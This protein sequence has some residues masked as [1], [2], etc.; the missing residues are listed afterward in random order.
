MKR[1]TMFACLALVLV[2]S[3]NAFASERTKPSELLQPTM[4]NSTLTGGVIDNAK[5]SRDTA[6]IIG[7]GPMV[8][9]IPEGEDGIGV[10]YTYVN[11]TFED[12]NGVASWNAWTHYDVTQPTVNHWQVSTFRA[13]ELGDPGNKAAWCGDIF[14]PCAGETDPNEGYG[15]SWNDIIEWTA[16]V[17]PALSATVNI[18]AIANFDSEPGYDGTSIYYYD[19]LGRQLLYYRDG[20]TETPV[21]IN[22]NFTLQ[23]EDYQGANGDQIKIQIAFQADGAWSDDDC[24]YPT[25]GA[26]QI[27]NVVVTYNQGGSDIV[28]TTDFED[29]TL[30]NWYTVF[31]SGVGDFAQLW[32]GLEDDDDCATNYGPQVAFID[33]GVIVPGVGPSVCTS[34]CYGPEGYIVN[35]VGGA[36]GP[37]ELLQV[38]LQSPVIAWPDPAHNGMT[39]D[40]TVYEHEPWDDVSTGMMRTWAIRSTSSADPADIESASWADRN[41]VYYGGPRY[42]RTRE[43]VGDLLEPGT[44]FVQI[45]VEAYEAGIFFGHS[46]TDGTPAPYFDNFRVKTYPTFGPSFSA[47][48][49]DLAQDNFPTIGELDLTNLG[50]NDIRFDSSNQITP[51]EN[52]PNTPGDSLVVDIKATRAGAVFVGMPEIVVAMK[53][54]PLFDAYRVLPAGFTQVD[55]IIMGSLEGEQ[56]INSA[57][58]PV[59]DK[60]AFDLPDEDFL[61]PGDILHYCIRATDDVGGDV[62]SA[63]LPARDIGAE[64]PDGF[65]D[66]SGALSYNSSFTVRGLPSL[67]DNPL[68]PGELITPKTLFWNDFANRGGEDEW[69]SALANL[70]ILSGV[71]YDTYYTNG[72][73]SGVGNGLGGRATLLTMNNYDNLLYSAGNLGSYTICNGDW[74]NGDASNDIEL[75]TSWLLEGNKNA[76]L[77]GDDLVFDLAV[78][79]QDLGSAFVAD[80]MKVNFNDQDLNPLVGRQTSPIVKAVA[81]NGVL[82]DDFSYVAY[83]GCLGINTFDAVEANT[84]AGAVRLA[85]FSD[86]SGGVGS[87]DFSALTMYQDPVGGSRVI[88]MPYDLMYIQNAPEGDKVPAALPARAVL[89]EKILAVFGVEGDLDEVSPV[90]PG[91]EKFAVRNY[92]NPF[93]PTTKIEYTMPKAGHLTLKIYN[94]RGELVKTLIDDQ[95]EASGHV[96]W[97][98]TN[99]TGAKVSSGVYFYEART[100]GQVQVQKMALVK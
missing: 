1:F 6:I 41:F 95:I 57:G 22:E 20:L 50:N 76:F 99:D 48:E 69:H 88:S 81:G 78:K 31:P 63:T 84:G 16:T 100:A 89:L 54:N 28:D 67:Y 42:L 37:D 3:L 19:A 83:G 91:A 34:Y 51:S 36:A 55:G 38:A 45:Q 39:Y 53:A 56:A 80:W 21:T 5:A 70:G 82:A 64:Y 90:L 71:D 68:N 15:N 35:P 72:P 12:A 26:V 11:G 23:P 7:P 86:P 93:N 66:F 92:P 13:D 44:T 60:Y 27:D 4:G 52:I 49:L 33:D 87:Y 65:L 9:A 8:P 25:Q 98:G 75:L 30:G 74:D 61:Y 47:R 43:V 73:S 10:V 94:V 29:D 24:L 85:E 32:E 96:M 59:A 58:N 14:A 40:H 46:G 2:F 77:T 18:G 79:Q 97:D 17:N 62:Q